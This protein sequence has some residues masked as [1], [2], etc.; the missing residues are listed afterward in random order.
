MINSLFVDE[1]KEIE[2]FKVFFIIFKVW[3]LFKFKVFN[4]IYGFF[5]YENSF[6]LSSKINQASFTSVLVSFTQRDETRQWYREITKSGVI[7]QIMFA[8]IELL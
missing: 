8:F 3:F 5:L 7:S 1:T 6:M 2:T 4:F